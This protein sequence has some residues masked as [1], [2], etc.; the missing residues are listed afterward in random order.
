ML[1]RNHSDQMF[2][3]LRPNVRRLRYRGSTREA[4]RSVPASNR[5]Q[6]D[7]TSKPTSTSRGDQG[8]HP[9]DGQ[10]RIE[11]ISSSPVAIGPGGV[12]HSSHEAAGPLTPRKP[13]AGPDAAS[14]AAMQ[15]ISVQY[16]ISFTRFTT[17]TNV[18]LVPFV[19]THRA[20]ALSAWTL[21]L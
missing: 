19:C 16:L 10:G 6:V 12:L 11:V 20:S 1:R 21:T 17:P 13:E 14:Q 7:L 3:P 18:C 4:T 9:G 5:R 15:F 8:W 2:A